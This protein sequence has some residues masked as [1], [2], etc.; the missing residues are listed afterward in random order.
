MPD[1]HGPK[2]LNCE[3][4]IVVQARFCTRCGQRT[5]TARLSLADIVRD[6]MHAF[7]NIERSPPAFAWALLT[8]P[9]GVA[10]EYVDGKRRRYFGPFATLAVLVGVTA[11]VVNLSG[12]RV[13]AHDGLATAPADLL[14]RHINLVLLAQLPLLGVSCTLVFRRAQLNLFEHMALVAYALI[15]RAAILALLVLIEYFTSAAAPK[16]GFVFAYWAIWYLYFGWAASQFYSGAR[17]RTWIE[18]IASALLAHGATVV[19]L[20]AGS[21]TLARLP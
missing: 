9:G 16:L 8:R 7:V 11:L 3:A 15:V 1:A 18:G 10:R 20:L 19:L 13:L 14:Q 21:W 2:C 12:Y 5:D 6:L 17:L 4:K